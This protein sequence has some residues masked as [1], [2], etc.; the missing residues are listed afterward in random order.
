MG[1]H[2]MVKKSID[3]CDMHIRTDFLHNILLTGGNTMFPNLPERL[4]W[5]VQQLFPHARPK[6]IAEPQ[7][8]ISVWIGGSILASLSTF[9]C[10]W[11]YANSDPESNPP[12]TGYDDVGP[13][14]VHE[15]C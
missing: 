12:I 14:I 6:V 5:E 7:R 1:L 15:M 2:Q 9:S 13:R 11:I 3:D 8:Q 10:M 4:Q